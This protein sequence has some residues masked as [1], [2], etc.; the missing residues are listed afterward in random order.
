MRLETDE[1]ITRYILKRVH[2]DHTVSHRI[3][4]AV[5]PRLTS[6]SFNNGEERLVTERFR[7][8]YELQS[9]SNGY[10]IYK[11]KGAE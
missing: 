6:D 10:A 3:Y 11:Y 9:Y 4:Y 2:P 5:H 7:I 1:V 8:V